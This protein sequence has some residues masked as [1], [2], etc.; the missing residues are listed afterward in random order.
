LEKALTAEN[1]KILGAGRLG[2]DND[3]MLPALTAKSPQQAAAH[4]R[5]EEQRRLRELRQIVI[6]TVN[7]VPVRVEDVADGGPAGPGADNMRGVLVGGREPEGHRQEDARVRAVVLRRHGEAREAVL[8]GA[9]FKIDELNE[10]SGKLLPGV[11]IEIEAAGVDAAG[12]D[13]FAEAFEAPSD[14][15]L[16]KV[17]GPDLEALAK[18]GETVRKQLEAVSGVEAVRVIPE[19]G[20]AEPSLHVDRQKCARW[21]VAMADV[22]AVVNAAFDGATCTQRVEGSELYDVVVRWPARCRK[23]E[24]AIL[25]LPVDLG[26]GVGLATPRLRLRDV[27]APRDK[28]TLVGT[29]A[30]HRENGERMIAVRFRGD[31][32]TSAAA[33]RAVAAPAPYR[34]AWVGR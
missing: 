23:D 32:K 14:G 7:Q 6:T 30:I 27:V 11:R 18:A 13:D 3:P 10:T 17:F 21:G 25:N 19:T 1:D 24:E 12:L 5:T 34:T 31:A 22:A 28:D 2:G 33:R 29:V 9:R 8:R 20:K 4:L 15:G 16:V 26:S